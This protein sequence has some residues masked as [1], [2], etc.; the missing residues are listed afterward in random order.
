MATQSLAEPSS[1]TER[2]IE[3]ITEYAIVAYPLAA[4]LALIL[5]GLVFQ[6]VGNAVEAGVAA[7]SGV[8]ICGITLVVYALFWALGKFGH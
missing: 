2:T 1:P 3:L 6:A 7:A 4:G 8:I 5:L